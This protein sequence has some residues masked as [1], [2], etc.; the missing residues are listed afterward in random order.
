MSRVPKSSKQT[1]AYCAVAAWDRGG[2]CFLSRRASTWFLSG[3]C[4][5][6]SL[7][8]CCMCRSENRFYKITAD[9]FQFLPMS[10]SDVSRSLQSWVSTTHRS[11][12]QLTPIGRT[13]S[14]R[15]S[16]FY[17]IIKPLESAPR[18]SPSDPKFWRCN[19]GDICHTRCESLSPFGRNEPSGYYFTILDWVFEFIGC[20]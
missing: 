13:H 3:S 7:T 16:I 5:V 9:V 2:G 4:L 15:F 17:K 8:T 12:S 6:L 10:V 14:W 20:C 18:G 11:Y 1:V 19:N